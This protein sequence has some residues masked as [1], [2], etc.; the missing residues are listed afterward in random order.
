MIGIDLGIKNLGLYNTET[1]KSLTLSLADFTDIEEFSFYLALLVSRK[2]IYVD[3]SWQLNYW[4]G[5]KKTKQQMIF[6]AGV[7]WQ[8]SEKCY[9]VEPKQIREMLG[10][11]AAVP[12]KELHKTADILYPEIKE[13]NSHEKDA[14][15]LA[16][17]GNKN[18]V[19]G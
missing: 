12:K 2:Y 11:A 4:P 18:E 10:F 9:F 3:Y 6:I 7:L 8:A 16:K 17:W 5:N 14:F 13:F 15:L 1:K 19:Y